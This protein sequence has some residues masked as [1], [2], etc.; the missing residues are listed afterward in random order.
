MPPIPAPHVVPPPPAPR[1]ISFEERLG[2]NWLNKLGIVAL[3]TGLVL[4]LGREVRTFGPLGKSLLGLTLALAILITGLVLERRERYR[5]FAR[6]AIGGGWAL[7]YFVTFALYHLPAMQVLQSQAT[8]LILMLGVAAV[9]V[10]HS[11]RYRSQ[12]VT[13]LAFLLAFFTVSIS[14]VT[15][16]SLVAGAILAVGLVVVAFREHWFVLALGGLVAVYLNHFLWLQRVLPDG[17]QPGH[18]FPEMLPSAAL[19]LFYWLLFRLFYIFRVPENDRDRT[20][21][22]LNV[23]L[24]STGLL[25]LLKFQST[26]P[27]WAFRGLLAL[28]I[29]ELV[30]AFVARRRHHNAFVALSC[31]ASLFLLAAVP[32]HFTGANWSL[33]WLLQ[34]EMLFVAG[35]ALREKVFRR[36]GLLSAFAA[37]AHLLVTGA[38]PVFNGRQVAPDASHHLV[39]TLAF[40]C[41]ALAAWF[42][43]E[44]A[45]RRWPYVAADAL[46]RN[47]L[48]ALSY[49]ASICAAIA[50]WL[51]LA[52]PWTLLPWLALSLLV[53]FVASRL[54]SR[55]LA[56]QADLLASLAVA[57]GAMINFSRWEDFSG[58]PRTIILLLAIAMTYAHM[59]RRQ[60]AHLYLEET[61]E[62]LYA[63]LG[64]AM[65]AALGWYALEPA[66][67]SVAWC[68]LGLVLLE[69]GLN[70]RKPFFLHQAYV[71]LAASF[72]RMFFT[73]VALAPTPRLYTMLPLALAYAWAYHRLDA[74]S[75]PE[76]LKR[77]ASDSNAWLS[78]ATVSTLL[79]FALR[80]S[81]VA[82]GGAALSVALLLLARV[83]RRPL[84]SAQAFVLIVITT[85]RAL[86]FNLF[87]TEPLGATFSETRLFTLGLTCLLLFAGLPIAFSVRKQRVGTTSR[88]PSLSWLTL[89]HPEQMLFFAPLAVLIAYVAV[90]FHGGIITVG[91][92]ALG[93]LTFLFALTVG[94]RSFRLAGLG[95]LLVGVA[96][97]IGVDIWHATSTDRYIT[98]IVMGVV[99]L[100]VSFL[101]S[102]YR[103]TILKL[104]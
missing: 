38:V 54:R 36:L 34:S 61:I 6:A 59:R 17:G 93:L 47:A 43:A 87:S 39:L 104:L 37:V 90:E 98:L 68:M 35:L 10:V 7:L 79:Y 23:V 24:N 11:L 57:R 56:Q 83:L 33:L 94:E 58:S 103:E 40:A 77:I 96:K 8:D 5:V 32:F 41:A 70:L 101:Y 91:W 86:A 22:T 81:W 92:S 50:L 44:F 19:L 55:D 25:A 89:D 71:L 80:P 45:V 97:I 18:A 42:N 31:I 100:L 85:A 82:I 69:L 15:L 52:G 13:S 78:L 1:A 88:E 99:L 75:E 66:A 73:N 51:T 28:G 16:F 9:M 63:W 12:V 67:V 27:E 72:V 49:V 62:P 95:L 26:H 84:F 65:L 48:I 30:L 29:A 53:A 64:T 2:Q 102:R 76:P 20:C 14:H 3:V 21:S 60:P 74:S 46:D 4:F